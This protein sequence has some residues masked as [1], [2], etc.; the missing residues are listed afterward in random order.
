MNHCC[1]DTTKLNWESFALVSSIP[2]EA[3][4]LAVYTGEEW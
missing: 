1:Y 3:A 4:R 2:E